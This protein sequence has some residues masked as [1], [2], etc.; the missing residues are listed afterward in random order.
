MRQDFLN[1]DE[2]S[3]F[4]ELIVVSQVRKDRVMHMSEQENQLLY[5]IARALYKGVRNLLVKANKIADKEQW[6]VHL[7]LSLERVPKAHAALLL[8]H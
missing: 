7:L 8:G 3:Q 6:Q 5:L 2:C 4:S 1:S